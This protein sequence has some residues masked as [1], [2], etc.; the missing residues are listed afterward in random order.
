MFPYA[1]Q[2]LVRQWTPVHS[3]VYGGLENVHIFPREMGP[4]ILRIEDF[5]PMFPYAVQFLVR[6]W[7]P[8]HS[9]VYGGLENVHIFPREMGP[10]IL[11]MILAVS[12]REFWGIF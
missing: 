7:T 4:R 11:R 9:S 10:R 5:W 12:R 1:V 6:Q 3:S 2:F 8:V